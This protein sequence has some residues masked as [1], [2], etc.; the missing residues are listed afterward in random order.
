MAVSLE[1]ES[2]LNKWLKH[3]KQTRE[4]QEQHTNS[5]ILASTQVLKE[6]Q[7]PCQQGKYYNNNKKLSP[8]VLGLAIGPQQICQ[9]R[10]RVFFFQQGK[11]NNKQNNDSGD[12]SKMEFLY[13][14]MTHGP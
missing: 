2:K 9:G 13:T 3:F 7:M 4:S 8:E 5:E 12:F 6:S 1:F 10:L 14:E 11:C